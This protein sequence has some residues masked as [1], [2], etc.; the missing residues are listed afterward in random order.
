V[1]Q[2]LRDFAD[3]RLAGI[4]TNGK[5]RLVSLALAL[6]VEAL[7][8]LVVLSLG[9]SDPQ[10]KPPG[11]NL[12]SVDVKAAPDPS[13]EP[14]KPEFSRSS[15]PLQKPKVTPPLPPPARP[16]SVHEILAR[17]V[18]PSGSVRRPT[19]SRSMPPPGIAN[20]VTASSAAIFRPP[21]GRAGR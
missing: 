9:W 11:T 12:V 19:A 21:T 3:D 13:P 18:I 1:L 4:R 6:L 14:E 16:G 17:Q 10:P 7:L 8:V 15:P 5:Q 20:L 2:P